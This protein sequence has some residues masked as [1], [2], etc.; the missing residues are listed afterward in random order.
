MTRF[1]KEVF[2][3]NYWKQKPIYI[4]IVA[5]IPQNLENGKSSIKTALH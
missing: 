1:N 3:D 4:N 2:K 5:K